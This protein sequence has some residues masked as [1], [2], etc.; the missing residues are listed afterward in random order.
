MVIPDVLEKHRAR[1][2]LAR[3][4]H[5]VLQQPE[6]PWLEDDLLGGARDAVRQP[7]QF[8]VCY[9]VDGR[10]RRSGRATARGENFNARQK[11]GEGIGLRD[12]VVTAGPETPHPVVDLPECR[13]DEHRGLDLLL[14]KGAHEG[15]AVELRQHAVDDEDIVLAAR[16]HGIAVEAVG[17][18]VGD[19]PCL[20]ERLNEVGGGLAVVLDDQ[21]THEETYTASGPLTAGRRE[22]GLPQVGPPRASRGRQIAV[23]ANPKSYDT[24]FYLTLGSRPDEI[25]VMFSRRLGGGPSPA[26][27]VPPA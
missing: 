16:R 19:M 10:L 13:K 3:M 25:A 8:E 18:V 27:S 12:V 23:G 26:R 1:N 11:F 9:T 15:E 2:D 20:A 5:E 7:V 22:A 6:L 14:A 24:P 17:R 21:N 4:L